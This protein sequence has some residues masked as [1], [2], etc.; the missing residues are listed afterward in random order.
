MPYKGSLW[1]VVVGLASVLCWQAAQSAPQSDEDAELYRLFVDAV[2][3]IDSSY[4][5]DVKRRELVEAAIN[6]MLESLD[7][8]STFISKED[9]PT[10]EK[11]T[12]G[13]YG[14]IGVQIDVR[15]GFVV[16]V[17]PMVG[18]PAYEAGV[19]AGDRIVKVN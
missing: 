13:H 18:S 16:V 14:G 8:Y 1:V 2:E 3:H 9:R 17:S 5:K 10:F 15:G 19:L 6:G 7:P 12:T 4:V 11:Q